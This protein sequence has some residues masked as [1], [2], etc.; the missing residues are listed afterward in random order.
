MKRIAAY[1][2]S[3]VILLT[4][5]L[6]GIQQMDIFF[7]LQGSVSSSV[8]TYLAVTLAWMAGI[9]IGLFLPDRP[10][11]AVLLV[12]GLAAYYAVLV[13]SQINAYD[14]RWLPVYGILTAT[15]GAFAGRFFREI[16]TLTQD[17]RRL[18]LI[19]N[20]GFILGL[21]ASV[22]GLMLYGVRSAIFAPAVV[23]AVLVLIG[24]PDREAT[25]T[26]SPGGEHEDS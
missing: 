13:L 17:S 11:L 8:L 1:R 10:P 24:F 26:G 9:A 4:G 2:V 7:L 16:N 15:A 25:E 6:L 22:I 23:G 21:I 3:M 18:F 12:V 19:E 14:L 5:F 20:N